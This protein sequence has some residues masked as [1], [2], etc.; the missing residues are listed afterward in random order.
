MLVIV[1][2]RV[3]FVVKS[4]VN[5]GAP[6]LPAIAN[7]LPVAENVQ[8]PTPMHPVVRLPLMS[9]PVVK[10]RVPILPYEVIP[11]GQTTP[12]TEDEID[13]PVEEAETFPLALT[14]LMVLSAIAA[15]GNTSTAKA[16]IT[17]N[18]LNFMSR[19]RWGTEL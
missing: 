12:T 9:A 7:E 8:P 15:A 11:L 1:P 13:I 6:L 2:M 3:T 17:A 16:K 5:D 18:L 10:V 14:Q 19:L 4:P